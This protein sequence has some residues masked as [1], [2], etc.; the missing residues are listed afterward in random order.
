MASKWCKPLAEMD[1]TT[2]SGPFAQR[3]TSCASTV[4]SNQRSDLAVV[5]PG[6]PVAR[7][8][9]LLDSEYADEPSRVPSGFS[10]WSLSSD[11]LGSMLDQFPAPAASASV[12]PYER[13]SNPIAA[14]FG[15][16]PLVASFATTSVASGS[17]P[18]SVDDLADSILNLSL[19]YSSAT[20][21]STYLDDL[22]TGRVACADKPPGPFCI[23][24]T[25]R[26]DLPSIPRT[27]PRLYWQ[28]QADSIIMLPTVDDTTEMEYDVE[29][30]PFMK[31]LY[32]LFSPV[33]TTR[34]GS[35]PQ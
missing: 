32:R 22:L 21:S 33:R 34:L 15:E 24:S 26:F 7:D 10:V 30:S 16:R 17:V 18:D 14:D 20:M 23:S 28:Q 25:P 9:S 1:S 4:S 35:R 29:N 12:E 31:E 5:R 27:R 19:R 3:E 2:I 13:P 6:N 8:L 11:D